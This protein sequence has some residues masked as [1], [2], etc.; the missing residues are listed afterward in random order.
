MSEVLAQALRERI[1]REGTITFAAFMEAALY[2]QDEGFYTRPPVGAEGHFLTGPHVSPLFG[3]LL[4]RQVAEA[5]DLLGA[6]DPF[7]VVEFG[8]GDGTLARQI[9]EGIAAA[10]GLAAALRYVAV[11]RS[12]GARA[13]LADAGIKV[14]HEEALPDGLTG[15]VLANELLD[16]LP[17]HILVREDGALRERFVALDGERFA[18][19]TATLSD[20][21]LGP[22]AATLEEG[23]E[24]AVGAGPTRWLARAAG[25]LARGYVLAIDYGGSGPRAPQG[26]RAHRTVEDLLADPG[27]ADITAGVDLDA[28]AGAARA[29]GLQVWGPVSQRAALLRLGFGTYAQAERDRTATERDAGDHLA[30][31][32]RWARR[33]RESL[34]VDPAALGGL[35]VMCFGVN[36]ATPLVAVRPADEVG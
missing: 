3:R 28:L 19:V 15:L 12:P 25:M 33:S 24:G 34:L 2:D 35:Q 4:A 8:A 29:L 31:A 26:Y 13:A 30:A 11:E 9:I 10:P 5:Y 1:A 27:S 14:A 20:P 18:L 6:P 32:R 23:A 21:T 36:V 17:F 7:H 22:L 16:N